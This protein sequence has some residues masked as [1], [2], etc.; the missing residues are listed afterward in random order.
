MNYIVEW[1]AIK[2][3]KLRDRS[4]YVSGKLP[5]YPSPTPTFSPKREVDVNVGLGEGEVGSFPE[6]IMIQIKFMINATLKGCS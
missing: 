6:M 3:E 1:H 2:A 4:L 5:T